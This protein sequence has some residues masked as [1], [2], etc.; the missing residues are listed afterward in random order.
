MFVQC[1]Y[2]SLLQKAK[3][4]KKKASFIF[5]KIIRVTEIPKNHLHGLGVFPSTFGKIPL[6]VLGG[7]VGKPRK[8]GI[9]FS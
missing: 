3:P 1:L 8:E 6:A 2:S 9:Q 4:E 7:Q 5:K